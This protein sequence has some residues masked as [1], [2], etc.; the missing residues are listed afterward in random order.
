[1]A[2]LKLY[3][4]YGTIE[5][6]SSVKFEISNV[7][8]EIF[9]VEIENATH[10][11]KAS[12][13]S[14]QKMSSDSYMGFVDLNIPKDSSQSAISIF[15]YIDVEQSDG[16][17]KTMQICPSVFNIK[18]KVASSTENQIIITPSYIGVEDMCAITVQGK[19]NSKLSV[20]IND[21]IFRIFINEEGTGSIHFKG[22]EIIK[23]NELE[24]INK[25][26]V[27]YY[28]EEDNYTNKVFS[29][30][31]L[32]ILPSTIALHTDVGTD[33]RCDITDP[34]YIAPGDWQQPDECVEP[35]DDDECNPEVEVCDPIVPWIP[36]TDIPSDCRN[37]DVIIN[38]NICR[39]HNN[40]VV[41]LNNGIVLYAYTSPDK[42]YELSKE[43][44]RYNINRVFIA[45][46][47]STLTR[48][49]LA[50]RDVA[51]E[52]KA[53]GEN[54]RIH[55]DEELYNAFTIP[56]DPSFNS[57]SLFAY[58]YVYVVLYSE[59]IGF[60]RIQILNKTI[61]EYT[62]AFIFIGQGEN[63]DLVIDNWVFCVNSVFYNSEEEATMFVNSGDNE[64][65]LPFVRNSS[66]TGDYVQP[67][68]VTIASNKDYIGLEQESYVYF[69]VEAITE[70]N[71]SQ[72]YFNSLSIGKDSSFDQETYGWVRLTDSTDGNN[73]HPLAKMDN[74]NNLHVIFESDRGGI[75]QLY[76][77]LLGAKYI[78][79]VASSFSSSVDKY[80]EFL[81]K[82]EKPFDYFRPLLLE[83]VPDQEY[84]N[85]PEYE[86]ENIIE[87]NWQISQRNGGEVSEVD[88]VN[89]L[90]NII[91]NSNPVKQEAMAVASLKIVSDED[92][93]SSGEFPYSQ[94]N[95]QISFDMKAE[96][97]QIS[98]LTDNFSLDERDIDNLFDTW[99]S[100]FTLSNNEDINNQPV[101]LKEDNEFTIGRSDNI[102]DRI[103]PMVGAYKYEVEDP[104]LEGFKIK[105]LKKN[106]NLKDF[107]F[108]LMFE[109]TYFKATNILTNLYLTADPSLPYV[110]DE[111]ETIYTGRAKL[112][113]LI[114]T[115]GESE[116][117]DS[118]IIAREFPE[119]F[120]A[121]EFSNYIIMLNYVK[122]SSSEALNILN[123]YDKT[124]NDA[125]LG[126][127]TLLIG[128]VPRFSQ[129]FVT[130]LSNDYNFFDIGFGSP[131]GGYY[132]ADKMSPSKMGVFDDI[133]T[134]LY[135]NNIQ[136]T[137]P[138]YS[139]N[140]EVVSL[141][142]TIRDMTKLRV[143]PDTAIAIPSGA[144]AP[145]TSSDWNNELITLNFRPKE[146]VV[147]EISES[148]QLGTDFADSY[149]VS[150]VEKMELRF[151]TNEIADR[152]LITSESGVVLY[153]SSIL[154][155][156]LYSA[157]I[158]LTSVTTI[159]VEVTTSATL[160]N[161]SFDFDFKKIYNDNT[162]S[163]VPITFEGINQSAAL[164]IG[165]CNDVHVAWQ[166]NRDKYWDIYYM[167]ST[168]G[169][170][171]FRHEVQITN[172]ESNSLKPSLSVNRNGARM[173]VWHDD[174]KNNYSVYAARSISGYDCNQKE[175]ERKMIEE[176]ETGIIKCSISIPFTPEV[177]G[178]YN[179]Y[180]QFYDNPDLST[181]YK[182]IS[183]EGNEDRWFIDGVSIENNLIYN[184]SDVLQGVNLSAGSE[185][186]ISYTPD[187]NDKIFDKVLYMILNFI[188]N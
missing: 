145:S 52:P 187:K 113:A 123:T 169:L 19:P 75:N 16:L 176:I 119:V 102:F 173:I 37:G 165:I 104:S 6:S 95:Y 115:E 93:P 64:I 33:P 27:H 167:N 117:R 110:S 144:T 28:S 131:D 47:R 168:N 13:T 8:F 124:Y 181:L 80:S 26:P 58:P 18:E 146:D 79:I 53:A 71:L 87:G 36:P 89:Y 101:Y 171:P 31:Y 90:N 88:S 55:V 21:K 106:N 12:I 20:S 60:Q 51:V 73:R 147:F 41:L 94:F 127:I 50:N 61:D 40:S 178:I 29:G 11:V 1:M 120:D 175:C 68:N 152:L 148:E 38:Q 96:I 97:S 166:S 34:A 158:D 162:F 54:F 143:L 46:N 3:P 98:D 72:L 182:T 161:W 5:E 136:I 63:E 177:A 86:T 186:N 126:T 153:D 78:P 121:N 30:I 70:N 57:S 142:P 81:S 22:K 112:V 149:D 44:S 56:D 25:L 107:V 135:F 156:L 99:K 183:I 164:D 184:A 76:Y 179:F 139:Y 100:E 91:I 154:P 103:V 14:L 77:G 109:K 82:T 132:V 67:V 150:D 151:N 125:F 174:R 43:D 48:H 128:E 35:P 185:I 116:E 188:I 83:E 2:N 85:I 170:S 92:N 133:S 160:S 141:P 130:T 84:A 74:V 163:Q 65:A 111:V 138:T 114:K 59:Y 10:G 9:K 4:P 134:A 7:E 140:D 155:A 24:I 15:A 17:Y 66:E 62:G 157:T 172:T 159:N 129:S 105:I 137:S 69:I 23:E 122:I 118:Y 39:V 180:I 108:G 49:I 32:H 42:E 45:A